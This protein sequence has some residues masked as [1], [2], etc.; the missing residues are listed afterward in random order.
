MVNCASR[1][2]SSGAGQRLKNPEGGGK[3]MSIDIDK[4]SESELHDLNHR[5]VE[6]LRFMRET[7]AHVTMLQFRIGQRVWFPAQDGERVIGVVTRH[8]RKSVTV[9]SPDGVRWNVAP[10]LLQVE[11]EF[12]DARSAPANVVLLPKK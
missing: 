4:L 5:I 8:N 1:A 3:V 11:P 7:R 9:V 12:V 10:G 2:S 6:R